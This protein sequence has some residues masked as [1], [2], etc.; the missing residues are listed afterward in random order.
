M[1]SAR[2]KHTD[3][4][5]VLIAEVGTSGSLHRDVRY[6]IVLRHA[7]GIMLCHNQS[8][9]AAALVDQRP[10]A[11]LLLL[12]P[13]QGSGVRAG[14]LQELLL[15]PLG[16][17]PLGLH[18]LVELEGGGGQDRTSQMCRVVPLGPQGVSPRGTDHLL[19]SAE[20]TSGPR[21]S[22]ISLLCFQHGDDLIA[23]L[24]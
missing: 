15:H 19:R 23:G 3:S 14:H 5:L 6:V 22:G 8:G 10:V 11:P 7:T 18:K 13:V 4:E 16:G 1:P 20:A 9:E 24:Q 21:R 12:E 2:R 17:V